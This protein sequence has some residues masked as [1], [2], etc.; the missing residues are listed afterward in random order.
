M[1]SL[2]NITKV[3]WVTC[4]VF[5]WA[6]SSDRASYSSSVT[7]NCLEHVITLSI[8]FG[9]HYRGGVITS[10]VTNLSAWLPQIVVVWC[11]FG[12]CLTRINWS[13]LTIEY[14][15][16]RGCSRNEHDHD[17]YVWP[18]LTP[19]HSQHSLNLRLISVSPFGMSYIVLIF[20][21]CGHSICVRKW[22][23]GENT[24]SCWWQSSFPMSSFSLILLLSSI[25][26]LSMSTPFTYQFGWTIIFSHKEAIS[27][28]NTWMVS[29]SGDVTS[30]MS[31]A[32]VERRAHMSW[33]FN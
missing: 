3:V 14:C 17:N 6:V 30:T 19:F 32:R 31:L 4:F 7:M 25:A 23:R 9:F 2:K 5:E 12:W 20:V 11:N 21:Y 16:K 26:I 10:D 22:V 1:K 33:V 27:A 15:T 18:R 28:Q 24:S 13:C 29:K 8:I